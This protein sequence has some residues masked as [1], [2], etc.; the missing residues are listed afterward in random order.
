MTESVSTAEKNYLAKE[1]YQ[2]KAKGIRSLNKH[3]FC[4][5]EIM[6]PHCLKIL[7]QEKRQIRQSPLPNEQIFSKKVYS[8][9]D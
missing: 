6:R 7:E 3:S 5:T 9:R 2:D 1:K 8:S 4:V